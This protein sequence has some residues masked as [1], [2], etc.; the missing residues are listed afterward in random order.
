MG[1]IPCGHRLVVKPIKLEE[2]DETY[3]KAKAIGLELSA[4]KDYLREQQSVDRG[5][6]VAVGPTAFQDFH[7]PEPWC[8]VGDIIA[9]AKYSGKAVKDIDTQEDYL[10]INDEDCVAIL[11]STKKD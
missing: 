9:F 11:T 5:V 2:Y 1:V 10:V 7:A 6:V 4:N 3:R 8:K